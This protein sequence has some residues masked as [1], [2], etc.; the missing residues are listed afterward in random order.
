MPI[1]YALL[2]GREPGE[3]ARPRTVDEV[4]A[5]LVRAGAA[6]QSVIPWGGGTG[7]TYGYLPRAA[8]VVLDLSAHLDR[9]I[10]H[11]PGDLTV[12]VQ[13]GATLV[14]VQKVLARHGQFL[15]LDPPHAEA[16]A[17]IG[18]IVATNAWG[19]SRLGYGT[20][21]DWLIGLSVVDAGGRLIK[22]GGKVV[23][24]VTGYDLPKLHVGAL[25]TLG[26]L[27][28]A[29]FR[30]APLPE[31]NLVLVFRLPA[32]APAASDTDAARTE[33]FIRQLHAGP[34]PPALSVLHS[35]SLAQFAAPAPGECYLFVAFHGTAEVVRAARNAANALATEHGLPPAS[36]LPPHV[37]KTLLAPDPQS[38]SSRLRVRVSGPADGS[39]QQHNYLRAQNHWEWLRTLPGAGHTEAALKMGEDPEAAWSDLRALAAD[40]NLSVA[41]PKASPAL[42]D[43]V[44]AEQDAL[45][46]PRP[47]AFALMQRL[48]NALDPQ[49]TLNPGRFVGGI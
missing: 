37:E 38:G 4:A 33:T 43:P 12:T 40:R 5:I 45:W 14:D 44:R 22:G 2:L 9:V 30:V 11:E 36:Q 28:E 26:I 19:P 15:P 6:G 41:L 16:G 21:R 1:D 24:N 20:V 8:D 46:W 17:T 13:A 47:P 49:G 34:L 29:T 18:G 3:I 7:Q 48:K 10:A 27:V 32:A 35:G 31:T 39:V 25:G 23:K 42:R